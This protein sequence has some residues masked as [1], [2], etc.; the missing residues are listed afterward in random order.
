MP[1]SCSGLTCG[2]MA[3]PAPSGRGKGDDLLLQVQQLAQRHVEEVAAAAGRVQHAAPAASSSAEAVTAA[4]LCAFSCLP[5]LASPCCGAAAASSLA[6]CRPARPAGLQLC[7]VRGAAGP[8]A[9]A[10]R[11]AGCRRGWC[12]ARPAAS[13]WRGR[14][15][16]RRACRRS[17][18]RCCAQSSPAM[19]CRMSSA[20]L[21]SG[22]TS[23]SSNRPPLKWRISSAP[24]KPPVA[25]AW[26]S[27]RSC[28]REAV[29]LRAR[30]RT[31]RRE[32]ALGQQADV[33][34]KQAEQQA[35]QE[36]GDARAG[37]VAPLARRC[38]RQPGELGGGLLGDCARR[39]AGAEAFRGRRRRARRW[40]SPSGVSRSSSV[41]GTC[42]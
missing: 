7:P 29:G 22:S 6:R 11:S 2:D 26:K 18:A 38:S 17:K 8:S 35:D 24:K 3:A 30:R 33:F 5:R 28:W 9:P 19:P 39:S 1:C 31:R 12:S 34:G 21:S 40:S 42:A 14:G 41:S 25:I 13:A 32:E 4:T 16:A 15:C 23:A 37:S 36:V 10:P 20:S 27:W